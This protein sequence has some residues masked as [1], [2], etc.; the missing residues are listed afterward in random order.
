M[1][2]KITR[3][4]SSSKSIRL[5][6]F[7]ILE[8]SIKLS[9]GEFDLARHSHLSEKDLLQRA[10]SILENISLN[11]ESG[12]KSVSQLHRELIELR[13]K[14]SLIDDPEK[15]EINKIAENIYK[16]IGRILALDNIVEI[17]EY[18]NFDDS[19]QKVVDTLATDDSLL[20]RKVYKTIRPGYKVDETLVRPQEVIVYVCAS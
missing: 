17:E 8:S 2:G 16:E 6:A 19:M 7:S 18:G 20:D 4:F 14:I 1:F 15:I 13:D 11:E 3:L 10:D 5:L 9:N 12:S